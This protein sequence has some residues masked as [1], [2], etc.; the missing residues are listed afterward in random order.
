MPMQPWTSILGHADLQRAFELARRLNPIYVAIRWYLDAPY[1]EPTSSWGRAMREA[2]ARELRHWLARMDKMASGPR[3]RTWVLRLTGRDGIARALYV[4]CR[5]LPW[6]AGP[7]GDGVRKAAI[8]AADHVL[9]IGGTKGLGRVVAER[10]SSAGAAVTVVSRH[11]SEPSPQP[12]LSHIAADLENPNCA[13]D[14]VSRALEVAGPI[15]YLLFCQRYRG[16]GDPWRGELQV[17]LTATKT[18][19]EGFADQ[20]CPDGDRQ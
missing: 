13:G 8:M 7:A 14:I 9:V 19:I 16:T 3:S 6:R 5:T 4:G 1:C 15:R 11:K 18:I 10:F 17:S 2:P 12:A 20:F